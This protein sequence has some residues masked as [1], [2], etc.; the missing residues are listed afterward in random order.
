MKYNIVGNACFA[1][2]C[3][4]D[5]IKQEYVNPFIWC[6][7]TFK[8]MYKLIINWDNINFKNIKIRYNTAD[9][10]YTIIL[11]DYDIELLYMHYRY[12][13]KALVYTKRIPDAFYYDMENY[14][15]NQWFKHIERMTE[16]KPIFAIFQTNGKKW[17]YTK[18]EL[19]IIENIKSPYP[20]IVWDKIMDNFQA[21]KYLFRVLKDLNYIK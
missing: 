14:L 17:N 15:L 21:A 6:E 1:T 10:N 11:L 12:D 18:E 8:N 3:T 20:I 9:N 19:E 7:I 16:T 2:F 5:Y 4:R 13:P